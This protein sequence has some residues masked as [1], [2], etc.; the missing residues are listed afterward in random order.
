MFKKNIPQPSCGGKDIAKAKGVHREMGYEERIRQNYGLV[1]IRGSLADAFNAI[2]YLRKRLKQDL[3][4]E[5][6]RGYDTMAV[7]NDIGRTGFLLS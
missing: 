3:P 1:S 6:G 2:K 7:A 5:V 4:R